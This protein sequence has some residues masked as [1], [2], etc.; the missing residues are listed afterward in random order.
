MQAWQFVAWKVPSGLL[1]I[2]ILLVVMFIDTI[3]GEGFRAH[4]PSDFPANFNG[5]LSSLVYAELISFVVLAVFLLVFRI[6]NLGKR[7]LPWVLCGIVAIVTSLFY[8]R[9][10][11]NGPFF[12]VG[13]QPNIYD[14]LHYIYT[15]YAGS[16][17][18]FLIESALPPV[19]K[20]Q[21]PFIVSF[22]FGSAVSRLG[23][24]KSN[25]AKSL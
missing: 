23:K 24:Q 16:N 4:A 1:F 7:I 15:Y 18:D 11:Y 12:P 19:A 22:I 21:L 6:H 9:S 5:I 10:F 8:I 20:L 14:M 25:P 3:M 13:G 2:V 17:Q